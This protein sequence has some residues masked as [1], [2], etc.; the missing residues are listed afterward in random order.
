MQAVDSN[1]ERS[2][3]YPVVSI[4][5]CFLLIEAIGR[6]SGKLI[7]VAKISETIG[8]S[9]K[10][11]S[12]KS[13]ISTCK[14]FGLLRSAGGAGTL[15][16]TELSRRYLYP[17]NDQEKDDIAKQAF[18]TSPLYSKLVEKYT[19]LAVPSVERLSN[20]LLQDF[21]ITQAAKDTAAEQFILSA[22]QI[23]I[24][25]N[26][27]LILEGNE[28][29][30][31]SVTPTTQA[32]V[33]TN[34]RLVEIDRKHENTKATPEGAYRFEIPTLSGAVAQFFIPYEATVK[35]LDFIKKYIDTMLPDFI[36][37]LKEEK[38]EQ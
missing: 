3:L 20:I 38:S 12:F 10:T 2:T 27:I 11:N 22:E 35:D 23:G 30:P 36:T 26:G 5:E 37:N 17:T 8:M 21:K 32:R 33:E 1:K 16:L 34:E 6:I 24:L 9:T 7:S 29:D 18:L 14:Q 28:I 15:Q 13:K 25:Q 4:N 19:N 31:P